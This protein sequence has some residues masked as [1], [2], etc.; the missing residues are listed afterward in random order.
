M[1]S[2]GFTW[3]GKHVTN[4]GYHRVKLLVVPSGGGTTSNFCTCIKDVLLAL[5]KMARKFFSRKTP[6]ME[7][8][9]KRIGHIFTLLP[10]I[11]IF[12]YLKKHATWR[13][14]L[15]FP[16]A[17]S[18]RSFCP[19]IGN[20][21]YVACYSV[22]QLIRMFGNILRELPFMKFLRLTKLCMVSI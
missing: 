9:N 21:Q 7:G 13:I 18:W 8:Q 11:Q 5:F 4:M 20:K 16:Y 10:M 6:G 1:T 17:S 22:L 12:L 14:C 19:I 3:F 2:V 15:A